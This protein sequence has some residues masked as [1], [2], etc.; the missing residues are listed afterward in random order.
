MTFHTTTVSHLQRSDGMLPLN[1][2]QLLLCH[3]QSS[4][5][6]ILAEFLC[7][8]QILIENLRMSAPDRSD[9]E[10]PIH[11]FQV[12]AFGLR[13]Q[14]E[15][16]EDRKD[17]H[18]GEEEVDSASVVAHVEEHLWCESCNDEVPEPIVASG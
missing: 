15:H 10:E 8:Q 5:I 4:T 17:H 13:N 12:N 7:P 9:F 6:G 14:E 2:K 3:T 1:L 16:E 11:R 18:R